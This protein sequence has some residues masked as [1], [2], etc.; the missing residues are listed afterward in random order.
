MMNRRQYA[1]GSTQRTAHKA[2]GRAIVRR[3]PLHSADCHL[4]TAD[5]LLPTARTGFSFVEILFAV[6][7]LGV[8]F[9]MLAA[10]FPV[11]IHQSRASAE[12]TNSAAIARNAVKFL[13]S[14]GQQYLPSPPAPADVPFFH[15]ESGTAPD[16]SSIAW[17]QGAG[18]AENDAR[19]NL[20]RGQLINGENPRY[21]WTALYH[22][23]PGSPLAQ[24]WIITLASRNQQQFRPER[25]LWIEASPF[26]PKL[27][28]VSTEYGADGISRIQLLEDIVP[29]GAYAGADGAFVLI[30]RGPQRGR[31]YRLGNR[32]QPLDRYRWE[33][34]P[35]FDL[36]GT[37][38]VV[39][40][41][42]AWIVGRGLQNPDQPYDPNTNPFVGTAQD[43]SI[44]TT[45]INVR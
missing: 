35:G 12:E 26:T 5:C 40:D 15:P 29:T 8:G 45:F 41:T 23:Y 4:P 38:E 14:A 37:V 1:A 6:I 10:M 24:V 21:G 13:E 42:A 3:Q 25:D 34:T 2:C 33:L 11:A 44:Y 17:R 32:I 18:A 43:I 39:S 27:V 19:W 9:I 16:I 22:R 31:I 30:A 36:D 28:F 20:I 7:I